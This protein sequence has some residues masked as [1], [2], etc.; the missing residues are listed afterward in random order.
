MLTKGASTEAAE[1]KVGAFKKAKKSLA[2]SFENLLSRVSIDIFSHINGQNC[3]SEIWRCNISVTDVHLVTV[4][5]R[6]EFETK[7]GNC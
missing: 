4:S 7:N 1:E 3:G 6:S 2:T 5:A